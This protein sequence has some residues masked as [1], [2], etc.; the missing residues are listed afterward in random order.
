MPPWE[1]AL[2][3]NLVTWA[4]AARL[5]G[6]G[7]AR[8]A[9]PLAQRPAGDRR[10]TV[11]ASLLLADEAAP[12]RAAALVRRFPRLRWALATDG[13]RI[14]P[15]LAAGAVV[16]HLP[17]PVLMRALPARGDRAAYLTRRWSLLLTKWEP[18]LVRDEG[19]PFATYLEA[20]CGPDRPRPLAPIPAATAG[21]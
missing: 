1:A 8:P 18:A 21:P 19:A 15:L 6:G 2:S 4:R 7:P 20:C 17:S 13:D 16:E 11:L 9:N 12:E 5:L 10:P 14:A 3:R